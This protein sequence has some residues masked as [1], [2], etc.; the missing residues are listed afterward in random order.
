MIKIMEALVVE[1]AV[2]S[3]VFRQI[4]R[5]LPRLKSV[6]G[7]KL[8]S[9]LVEG[10]LRRHSEAETELAYVALDHVLEERGL[11]WSAQAETGN[12]HHSSALGGAGGSEGNRLLSVWK[13]WSTGSNNLGT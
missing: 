11:S 1:H 8:L 6:A 10:M 9:N 12:A 4:E 3:A 13:G 7:A 5:L 2:F